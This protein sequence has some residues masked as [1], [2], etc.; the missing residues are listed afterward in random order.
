MFFHA[1]NLIGAKSASIFGGNALHFSN[2]YLVWHTVTIALNLP[3]AGWMHMNKLWFQKHGFNYWN[4][5]SKVFFQQISHAACL[6]GFRRQTSRPHRTLI[7]YGGDLVA[8]SLSCPEPDG[9]KSRRQ[10]FL[11]PLLP[12]SGSDGCGSL[13]C[14]ADGWCFLLQH[15]VPVALRTPGPAR[16]GPL[17]NGRL[18]T[19][20]HGTHVPTAGPEVAAAS[21]LPWRPAGSS[22]PPAGH[23]TPLQLWREW[24]LKFTNL[25]CHSSSVPKPT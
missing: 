6:P 10:A 3:P 16:H 1:I 21:C 24:R 5:K 19:P 2:Y 9:H 20:F 18:Q 17:W 14:S 23:E 4:K 8:V 12:S 22:A 11:Q 13:C 25:I 15:P 7:V